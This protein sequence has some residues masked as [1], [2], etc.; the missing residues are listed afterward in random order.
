MLDLHG[1]RVDGVEEGVR[2]DVQ[3]GAR[4]S[5]GQEGERALGTCAERT[6]R[7]A[8]TL[9]SAECVGWGMGRG[10]AKEIEEL[11]LHI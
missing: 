9:V 3:R 11:G 6:G 10:R 5:E 8:T 2:G 1:R 7:G 4:L